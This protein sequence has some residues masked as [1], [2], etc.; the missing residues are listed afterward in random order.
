MTRR[1]LRLPRLLATAAVWLVAGAA[2]T[3]VA[4]VAVPNVVGGRSLK[5]LSGSMEPRIQTGDIVIGRWIRPA[6]A[7][8]GDVVTFRKPGTSTLI[9]HRARAVRVEDGTV[10]F[11]TKGDANETVEAWKAPLD[12]R[13]TRAEYRV[14]KAGYV[15]EWIGSDTGRWGLLV[16]PAVLLAVWELWRIWRPEPRGGEEAAGA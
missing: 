11:V 9:T 4:A 6:E 1:S 15:V 3:L 5:V 16:I 2:V 13:I 14:P 10:N 8:P 12:A 7:R